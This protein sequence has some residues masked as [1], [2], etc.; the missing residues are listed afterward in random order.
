MFIIGIQRG[1]FSNEAGLGTSSIVASSTS[2][3]DYK[4]QGMIQMFGIYITTLII[5]TSTAIILLSSDY[6]LLNIDDINGIELALH[7]FK[8]HFGN[9]G[10]YIMVI[11]VLLFSFSTV[12]TGYYYGESC[13][14]YFF[15]KPNIKCI[16]ILR[17]VT[18][19]IL[20]LGCIVSSAFLWSFVDILVGIIVIINLYAIWKLRNDLDS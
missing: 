15:D 2:N 5:C 8:Y 1:V 11:S 10:I 6:Y 12:L 18:L 3:D 9:I 14:E 16:Y 20:F 17:G 4:R 7:A 13:L 19:L